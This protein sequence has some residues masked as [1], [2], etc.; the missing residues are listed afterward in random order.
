MTQRYTPDNC[1]EEE[2]SFASEDPNGEFVHYSDYEELI[3][4]LR[5]ILWNSPD[6][7][8]LETF[9]FNTLKEAGEK[10]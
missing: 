8:P 3:R 1:Y 5:W 7:S 10:L 9:V 6:S 2:G 4:A